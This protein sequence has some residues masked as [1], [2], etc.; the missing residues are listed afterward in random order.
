VEVK[1][2]ILAG[3]YT[4]PV[5]A[6]EPRQHGQFTLSVEA[7]LP[8]SLSAIPTEGAGMY[9]RTLSGTWCVIL[10]LSC[11]GAKGR[12][13]ATSGGRPSGG[14]FHLNPRVEVTLPRDC[15]IMYVLAL[16]GPGGR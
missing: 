2:L 15:T 3:T 12:D 7:T 1:R 4:L 6:F 11:R 9:T 5:S 14:S 8:V 13:E 16:R 10:A